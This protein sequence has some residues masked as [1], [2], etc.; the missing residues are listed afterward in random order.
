[1]TTGGAVLAGRGGAFFAK[2]HCPD[3]PLVTILALE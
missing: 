3:Q 2:N 1:M